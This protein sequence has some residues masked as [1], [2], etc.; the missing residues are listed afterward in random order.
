MMGSHQPQKE[1]FAYRV[2]LDQRIPPD[3]VLRRVRAAVDF[4]FVRAKVA[5]TYG[6]NGHESVDPAILLKLMFLLFFDNV[7]SERELMR[8]LPYRLDYLWFLGMGLDDEVPNHS[9]LSKARARWGVELFEDLFVRMVTQCVEAGLVEGSK[10]HVDGSLI[11]A[12]ASKGSVVK[13]TPE[14]IEALRKAYRVEERKLEENRNSGSPRYEA[15]NDR[16]LST[17]D[18]DS[19][20]V[21]KDGESRPRYKQ[22]R[23]VDNAQGVIT[24]VKTT[25]GDV[26]EN[27]ELL[28]MVE[29]HERNTEVAVG[30]IVAD[31]QYGTAE[32]FRACHQRGIRSHMG[33]FQAPQRGKGRR[34]GIYAE[35]DFQ[36][37]PLTDTYRC[38]AGQTLT[39]RKH[40]KTRQAYEYS[41]S[42]SICR[43][44]PLRV[45]CT[46]A[47]GTAR[48]IKRHVGHEAIAAAR[49]QSHSAAARRDRIRRKWLMEGSF[50]D[51][52]NNHGFKRARWRRLWRQQIQDYLIATVQNVRILLRN[53]TGPGAAQAHAIERADS[54]TVWSVPMPY[55]VLRGHGDSIQAAWSL[56]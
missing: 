30:T 42:A 41:C 24:A 8:T 48:T 15:V 47:N 2:D 19:A 44:C 25:A 14:L 38:P 43:A 54:A 17:T 13:S 56:N 10:I 23:V 3:H 21:R 11:D 55:L 39:R 7:A 9:V 45:Q 12:N 32:N 52:A 29:Q 26:K 31:T 4:D 27:G 18:P 5:G 36:Y 35:E 22:H 46:R 1:L 6:Y 16:A 50:A 53:A 51:A 40:K 37:D 20:L 34:E 28:A 49:V 33:D